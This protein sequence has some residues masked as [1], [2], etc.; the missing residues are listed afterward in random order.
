MTP[1]GARI[2]RTAA[3]LAVTAATTARRSRRGRA[4]ATSPAP[5]SAAQQRYLALAEAGIARAEREWRDRRLG[6]FDSR[7]HDRDRYPLATIWDIVPLFESTDAVAIAA[8]TPAHLRAVTRFATGA[9]RY[10]NRGLRPV[11]GYSPYP[12]DRTGD[13]ETWFDD[14]GWWGL[15]FVNAY[16]AT[17]NHRWLADAGA[18]LRYIVRAGWDPASGGVWW[19]TEHPFKSGPAIASDALLATLLYEY[20]HASFDL[21]WARPPDR[22]RERARVQ[23]GR[24]PLRGQQPLDDPGRLHRGR[25]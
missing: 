10:L 9:E 24:R 21:T 15:A 1:I 13:T 19:N 3:L 20:Q 23:R 5:V 6:W 12:G 17:G 11:P 16:R 7:L 14:N 25:R 8:P 2:L 22:L 4:P 18:A